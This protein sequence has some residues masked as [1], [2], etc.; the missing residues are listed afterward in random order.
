[1]KTFDIFGERVHLT[2]GGSETKHRSTCGGCSSV[3]FVFLLV[4][5]AASRILE[6]VTQ[7]RAIVSRHADSSV[8]LDGEFTFTT[9][10]SEFAVAFGVTSH[11]VGD[12]QDLSAYGEF[13]AH[14]KKFNNDTS[15]VTEELPLPFRQCTRQDFGLGDTEKRDDRVEFYQVQEFNKQQLEKMIPLLQCFDMPLTFYGTYNTAKY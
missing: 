11:P 8:I 14:Y 1:M 9:V 2:I 12:F 13:I 7:D 4:L 10:K 6:I 15:G 5:F 3:T